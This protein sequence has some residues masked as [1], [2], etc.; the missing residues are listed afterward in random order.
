MIKKISSVVGSSLV[1]L[2]I[3]SQSAFGMWNPDEASMTGLP[4][5]SIYNIIVGILDWLL[6]IVG[7]VGVIAFAIAG[8]MYLTST[9]DDKRIETA[10]KAMTNAIIG[11]VVAI[12]GLVVI[13]AVDSMLNAGAFF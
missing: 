10:K 9:G 1:V 12:V 4:S 2:F 5:A 8:I 13:R 6:T 11:V 7:V 3:S